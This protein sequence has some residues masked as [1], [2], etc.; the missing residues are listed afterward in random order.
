FP[1]LTR[2]GVTLSESAETSAAI[3]LS[4]DSGWLGYWRWETSLKVDKKLRLPLVDPP[5][6]QDFTAGDPELPV[7][8]K[9]AAEVGG[10]AGSIS[11][12]NVIISLI[13]L[14]D[15]NGIPVDDGNCL[16]H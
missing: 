13:S 7:V 3:F 12:L 15:S 9:P 1:L 4:V 8:F 11:A 16:K 5:R 6:R 14:S 10:G 2:S